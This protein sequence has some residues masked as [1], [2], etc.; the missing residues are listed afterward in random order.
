MTKEFDFLVIGSGLAGLS[1]ALRVAEHGKVC[2]VSKSRI[3]ETNT[4]MAQG[5]GQFWVASAEKAAEQIFRV[6]RSRKSH[7]CVTRRWRM[8]ACFLKVLPDFIYLRI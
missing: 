7:A 5:D 1:Y 6:I 4:A 8:V 3:E 2:V